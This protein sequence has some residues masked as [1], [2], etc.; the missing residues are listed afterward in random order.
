M[1]PS[2]DSPNVTEPDCDSQSK[3]S[4]AGN[5]FFALACQKGGGFNELKVSTS[6]LAVDIGHK[7]LLA[8]THQWCILYLYFIRK[9][10]TFC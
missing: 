8:Q 4:Q 5:F 1:A 10:Q 2:S 6:A 3:R 7:G 9:K